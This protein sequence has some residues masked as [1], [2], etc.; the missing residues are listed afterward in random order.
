MWARVGD[1]D[2]GKS[3]RK[4]MLKV[5]LPPVL[6]CQ[7]AGPM[8]KPDVNGAGISSCCKGGLRPAAGSGGTGNVLTSDKGIPYFIAFCFIALY[9][10]ILFFTD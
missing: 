9:R 3:M 1:S 10:Y 7:K 6:H 4:S 5:S 8:V 2:K